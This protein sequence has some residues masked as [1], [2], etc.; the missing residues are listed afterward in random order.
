M[1]RSEGQSL[2]NALPGAYISFTSSNKEDYKHKISDKAILKINYWKTKNIDIKDIYYPKVVS[3][4]IPDLINFKSESNLNVKA[5][6]KLMNLVNNKKQV[7]FSEIIKYED[8]DKYQIIGHID[9]KLFYCPKCGQIKFLEN[10]N[11]IPNM[12]CT[13]SKC[14]HFEKHL[15]QYNR[16]WVC[17]CGSSY[18]IDSYDVDPNKYRYFANIKDGFVRNNGQIERIRSKKCINCGGICSME[19]ATD[20]KA[21]FPRIITSVKLTEDADASLCETSEGRKLIIERQINKI[22]QI[23]FEKRAKSLK[24]NKDNLLD[25]IEIDDGFDFLKRLQKVKKEENYEDTIEEDTVYKIL[26]YNYCIMKSRH[27]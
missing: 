20:P 9:P 17:S 16:I 14:S 26:E 22:S 13:N 12:K 6:G 7:V 24:E 27:G 23:E 1:K 8:E 5:D 21:F 19:N 18:F 11:D 25:D 2:Y 3:Q 10:D 15:H 4:I